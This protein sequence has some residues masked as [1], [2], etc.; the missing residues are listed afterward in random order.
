[1]FPSGDVPTHS[2]VTSR[3]VR[4]NRRSVRLSPDA[5][6]TPGCYA[7]DDRAAVVHIRSAARSLGLET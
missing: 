2:G 3:P 1:V 7:V 6:K 4:P 5:S